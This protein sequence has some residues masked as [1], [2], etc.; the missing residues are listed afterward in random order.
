MVEKCKAEYD[1]KDE[2][3]KGEAKEEQ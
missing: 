3:A 1:A 2:E